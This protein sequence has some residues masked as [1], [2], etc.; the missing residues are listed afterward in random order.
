MST[1]GSV[2]GQFA[3]NMANG[4]WRGAQRQRQRGLPPPKAAVSERRRRYPRYATAD[5]GRGGPR[6][7]RGANANPGGWTSSATRKDKNR[8]KAARLIGEIDAQAEISPGRRPDSGYEGEGRP[9]RRWRLRGK[10]WSKREAGTRRRD[11]MAEAGY[12]T[13]M[14]PF[15]TGRRCG[16]GV[17][18]VAAV[19]GL[20]GGTRRRSGASAPYLAEKIHELTTDANGTRLMFRRT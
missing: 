3:G 20:S 2:G 9:R 10:S 18:A 12:D 1:G 13:A 7:R 8:L 19:Q 11:E 4:V 17:G 6:P 15:G 5:A 16:Q 14:K